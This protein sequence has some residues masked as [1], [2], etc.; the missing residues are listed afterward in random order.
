MPKVTV[1]IPAYNAM[2]YLP[3]TVESVLAQT[4]ADFELLIINDGSSDHIVQWASQIADPRVK[5]ISQ[6]N[7][8]VSVA[9][10][11]GIAQAQGKYIAFL[12]A[13]DLWKPTKLEK[14]V[15]CLEE[16]PEAG[17]VYTWTA[18]VDQQG[19]PTKSV[20]AFHQEGNVW[21]Q[22]LVV[23]MIGNGSS[24][25]VRR[26]CFETVG[27]FDPNLSSAADR[28]MW[29]RIAANYLFAVVKE[30]LTLWRQHPSSMSKR[31]EEMIQDSRQ[32]IEKNFQSVPSELLYLRNRSYSYL[33]LY[34]A[35][36]SVDQG[37]YKEAIHFRR[38]AFLHYPQMGYSESY[39]R[40]SL[41]IILIRW[42]GP[43]GYDGVRSLTQTLRQLALGIST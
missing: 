1:V 29:I 6:E 3:K 4:L 36:N 27:M 12:D 20:I 15:S 38:Q 41:A 35:W 5:L 18:L 43:H 24:V 30:P 28:D 11:T 40:L 42:F 19:K 17:L 13:D 32:A 8:G 39:I 16:Y 33:N 23:D 7:Q 34:Q 21:E 2:E 10:N 14:Q 9:R 25:M 22:I 37:N 26:S 31:R